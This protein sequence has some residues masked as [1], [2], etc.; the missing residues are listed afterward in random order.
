MSAEAVGA[1]KGERFSFQ[2]KGETTRRRRHE[3]RTAPDSLF[4][5]PEIRDDGLVLHQSFNLLNYYLIVHFLD[6]PN[7]D[8]SQRVARVEPD[9]SSLRLQR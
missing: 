1:K 3:E 9:L 6:L 8:S 5:D 7:D 2:N 4:V